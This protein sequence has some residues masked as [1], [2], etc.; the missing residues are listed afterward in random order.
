[1]TLE[2]DTGELRVVDTL[3]GSSRHTAR[4]FWHLGPDVSATLDGTSAHL[5]W[6]GDHGPWEATIAL[7]SQLRWT[8]HRGETDP[9]L[10]W[11]SPRFG[12]REPSTT[13]VGGAE[14]TGTLTLCTTLWLWGLPQRPA[15]KPETALVPEVPEIT[16]THVLEHPG[17]RQ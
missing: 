1:V 8:A 17:G 13:L 12:E 14:W 7:P 16:L 3:V 10:G 15:P 6:T 11:Y 4:L 5:T 2:P 9:I